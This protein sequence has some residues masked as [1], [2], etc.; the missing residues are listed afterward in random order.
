[1]P[2]NKKSNE[3]EEFCLEELAQK[4]AEPQE[5]D[6]A[7]EISD[8][9][10]D[11]ADA[12]AELVA[13]SKSVDPIVDKEPVKKKRKKKKSIKVPLKVCVIAAVAIILATLMA[14]Y[15][16]CADIFKA[17]YADSLVKNEAPSATDDENSGVSPEDSLLSI[18]HR[19][20][21]KNYYGEFDEVAM[22]EAAMKAY[23]QATGDPYANY[24]TFEELVA[25]NKETAGNMCGVGINIVNT[26]YVYEGTSIKVLEVI[27]VMDNSP[28]L[29]AGMKIGDRVAMVGVGDNA[30]LVDT[31]GYDKALELLL[32][33]EGTNAEFVVLREENG[34]V[35]Q[36]PFSITRAQ[37]K[38]MS[39]ISKVYEADQS[40]GIL[41]VRE[42]DYT[43]PLQFKTKLEELQTKGCDKFIID[44]RYNPGGQLVSIAGVLSYFL[45]EGDVYIQ[46]KDVKGTVTKEQ[47]LPVT[48][49][50][51]YEDMQGCNILKENIG[52][53]KDL[54][55]VV[56]CN[57][58]TASAAELFTANFK[59]HNMG[60]VVGVKTYGKGSMQT[61]F[62]I[63]K[64]YL[65]AIKLTTHHYFSGGDVDLVGYNG[66]GIEP[67]VAVELS[68]E[69][70]EYNIYLLPQS[71]DNQLIAAA[72]AFN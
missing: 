60:T 66:V 35:T 32:G 5:V 20:I 24:F 11:T 45:D 16:V 61:T 62:P 22:I 67:D 50:E 4:T 6:I 18:L 26:T 71:I 41:N 7:E 12:E 51:E 10:T 40:I 48:Y 36:I 19:Y 3:S 14:T 17:K 64:G 33:E 72:E 68:E 37:V 52:I 25:N 9:A 65:G 55:F 29:D 27:N 21:D 8:A 2:E 47:I 23:V 69:A 15:C 63:E 13:E 44:L 43:T 1:M 58:Y 70:K 38:T 54:D 34:E 56:L 30:Q 28:A 39:V 42:F 46:T 57:E 31:L 53:Y 49:P 59:D